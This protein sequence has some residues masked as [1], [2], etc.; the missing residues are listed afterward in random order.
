M[1]RC[2]NLYRA[3]SPENYL[4]QDYDILCGGPEYEKWTVGFALPCIVLWGFVLPLLALVN[5]MKNRKLETNLANVHVYTFLYMGYRSGIF[6]WE[7]VSMFRKFLL[8]TLMVF[9]YSWAEGQ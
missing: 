4:V 7:F 8:L 9:G 3:D 6:Y 1:Y 2:T 5:M